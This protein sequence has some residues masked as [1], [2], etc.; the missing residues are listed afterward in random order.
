MSHNPRRIA[1]RRDPRRNSIAR[2][3]AT[4]GIAGVLTIAGC[5]SS[6]STASN[7]STASGLDSTTSTPWKQPVCNRPPEPAPKATP[8][9]GTPS[10]YD[11]TSFDET[12]IRIHWFPVGDGSAHPTV[13]MGPGWSLGGDTQTGGGG[14]A[15]V[16]GALG[17]P[18]LLKLKYNVL[19]WDPRGFGKSGGTVEVDSPDFEAKDVSKLIDWVATQT[20]VQL[21]A[22]GDPRVGMVGGSYGGGIQ[23]V[24]AATDCRVDVI[25]P[26]IAW[27]SLASS[28]YKA[29]TVKSG[30]AD[31]LTNIAAGRNLD[32]HILSSAEAGRTT[33]ILT[34]DERAWFLARGPAPLLSQ[35][36]VPTLIVQGTVDNLFTLDEGIRNYLAIAKNG[37][38]ISMLWYCGGHGACLTPAG[39][40]KLVATETANWLQRYLSLDAKAT[41]VPGFASVDQNGTL[42]TFPSYPV[43]TGAPVRAAGR[44]TLPLTDEGGAGP[45][46]A[47]TTDVVG[48]LAMSITPGKATNAVNVTVAAGGKTPQLLLGSPTLSLTYSGTLTAG[49]TGPQRVFAQLVD[50]K[51]GTVVGNQITPI[52]VVLDG[53]THRT[54]V[55]MEAIAFEAAPGAKLT[56][57]LVATTVLYAKPALGGSVHFAQI[58][59]EIPTVRESS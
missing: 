25:V 28:L 46:T 8:V 23:L 57:Q 53:K 21:D 49:A 9:A 47:T 59:L 56:L 29:D 24:T 17:I 19:T 41:P 7:R 58:G 14:T 32:P 38:P 39:D 31:V 36:K 45:A 11:I 20:G 5:S 1:S 48:K 52:E 35:I 2:I 4:F 42:H 16:L 44:G 3:A 30:W 22:K 33:G 37:V 27:N 40:P 18:S 43:D 50:D 6:G 13:L 26:M 54:S 12:K 34:P 15:Q 10:D 51:T 55:S